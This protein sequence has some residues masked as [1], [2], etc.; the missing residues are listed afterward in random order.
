MLNKLSLKLKM[1]LLIGGAIIIL[2]S[3][4]AVT[5]YYFTINIL[6]EQ[7]DEQLIYM[8]ETQ[9]Q[10]VINIIDKT[11]HDLNTILN[12]YLKMLLRGATKQEKED[13]I[14]S[15]QFVGNSIEEAYEL[16]NNRSSAIE[17]IDYIYP[18]TK[19]GLLFIDTI[20]KI[21]MDN[22]EEKE[23]LNNIKQLKEEEYGNIP[24]GQIQHINN[25]PYFLVSLP[26]NYKSPYRNT[27]EEIGYIVGAI[28][29]KKFN[30]EINKKLGR[31]GVL[32]LIN[33]DGVVVSATNKNI[34]GE[35]TQNQWVLNQI[36]EKNKYIRE[37][38][39]DTHYILEKIEG[40]E[41]YLYS[42]I[43]TNVI[44]G[45]AQ[46]V[47][48]IIGGIS[49]LIILLTAIIV[50]YFINLNL[51]PLNEVVTVLSEL[52]EGNISKEVLLSEKHEKNKDEFGIVSRSFN[53]TIRNIRSLILNI[54][55]SS[56]NVVKASDDI[57]K[58]SSMVADT[59]NQV[60][61]AMQQ[62][63]EGAEEQSQ[64]IN[65]TAQEIKKLTNKI[66]SINQ[67][68]NKMNE[69]TEEVI[70]NI[71]QGNQKMSQAIK[72]TSIMQKNTEEV[73]SSITDLNNKS[74][75]ISNIVDLINNISTQT[76]LL[77]LNA[78]IEAARAGEAGRGFSVVADEIR[79]LAEESSNATDKISSILNQVQQGI[80]E[81][82]NKMDE[83]INSVEGST[84][85]IKSTED[86]FKQIQEVAFNLTKQIKDINNDTNDM[87]INSEI[88][89]NLI[90]DISLLSTDFT[91]NAEEVAASSQEQIASTEEIISSIEQLTVLTNQLN[92]A[93][94]QFK[95]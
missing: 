17:Y 12:D 19:K 86:I 74:K 93:I 70:N 6:S 92:Q 25:I 51:S 3:I 48:L 75:E 9:K 26:I 22:I 72:E 29:I 71:Q 31:Y 77:A 91:Q 83:G 81:T 69:Y 62:I 33:T 7:T 34:I 40:T 55:K 39:Q 68:S 79:K 56:T 60:G 82:I 5:I 52:K 14:K 28:N 36:N 57:T 44:N 94:K 8:A 13:I 30:N 10:N 4:L 18:V 66:D 16:F 47:G 73:F 15:R 38:Q 87:N 84:K 50:Y 35:Q 2:L 54:S 89:S 63:A 64:Q 59:A 11:K 1:S 45:P 65:N 90:N 37:T 58:T 80:K 61:D 32:Q 46:T 95:L 78:A 21:D 41:L 85:A 42:Q 49:L 24:F 53:N 43:Y 20:T 88:V 23:K 76:N 67:R 27:E